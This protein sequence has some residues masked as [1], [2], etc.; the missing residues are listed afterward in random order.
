MKTINNVIY[1]YVNVYRYSYN[2]IY[3]KKH[4]RNQLLT[5]QNHHQ[6]KVYH[7]DQFGSDI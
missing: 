2:D 5:Y 4:L 7:D 6:H 1:V 3:R